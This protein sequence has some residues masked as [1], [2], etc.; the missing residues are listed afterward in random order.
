MF[1]LWQNGCIGNEEGQDCNDS[2]TDAGK[3]GAI[4]PVEWTPS[5]SAGAVAGLLGVFRL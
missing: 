4:G 2:V 3:V 5:S 1:W